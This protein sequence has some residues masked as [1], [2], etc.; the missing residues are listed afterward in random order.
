[1][2]GTKQF[3]HLEIIDCQEF[4]SNIKPSYEEAFETGGFY[5]IRRFC[6]VFHVKGSKN[7]NRS[8]MISAIKKSYPKFKIKKD[9]QGVMGVY[10]P[11]DPNPALSTYSYKIALKVTQERKPRKQFHDASAADDAWAENKSGDEEGMEEGDEDDACVET[12]AEM[13]SG[14]SESDEEST[15]FHPAKKHKK[16]LPA[17][18]ARGRAGTRWILRVAHCTVE[19]P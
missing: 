7:A 6:K 14:D 5:D 8:N 18:L 4:I 9:M 16:G 12:L 11:H 19:C 3:A 10:Y 1:M 15:T 13:K 2:L 17:E